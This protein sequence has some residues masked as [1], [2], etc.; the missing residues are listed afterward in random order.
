MEKS[1]LDKSLADV[2]DWY[3]ALIFDTKLNVVA[4]KNVSVNEKELA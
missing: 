1:G 2:E 4:A 3:R